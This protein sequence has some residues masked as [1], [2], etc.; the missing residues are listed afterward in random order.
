M[1]GCLYHPTVSG[2]VYMV[3]Y[4]YWK[5]VRRSLVTDLIGLKVLMLQYSWCKLGPTLWDRAGDGMK[6]PA[7]RNNNV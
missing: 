2:L 4:Y 7:G 6:Y 5:E 3:N 1:P